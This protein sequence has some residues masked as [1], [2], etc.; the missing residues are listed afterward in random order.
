MTNKVIPSRVRPTS[1]AD[2][3]QIAALLAEAGLH[4]NMRPEELHWKYWQPRSDWP[5]PR[6]F[7]MARNGE[8]LAHAGIV[9]GGCL[10]GM[11]RL[12][13]IH[14]VDWAA[15][16]SATGAGVAL[17]KHIGRLADALLSIGGS[18]HTRQIVP[19]LGFQPIGE[20]TAYVRTLNPLHILRSRDGPF[21]KR[22]PRVAR[23]MW[24]TA[25][26]PSDDLDDCQARRIEPNGIGALTPEFP[27]S[28][29]D[30]ATFERSD[31]LFRYILTCP[32]TPIELYAWQRNGEKRGY[33]LLAFA[34]GQV[35]LADCWVRSDDPDDWR[36]LVQCA[37]RWARRT[38]GAAELVAWASDAVLSHA[39]REC[40]FHARGVQP[41]QLL[42]RT[43]SDIVR[44]H[45]R[46]QML[47]SDAAYS[48]HG[49]PELWA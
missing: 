11:G 13:T 36:A 16:P 21:W 44:A 25:T 33:F 4:P 48:H 15:H 17:M 10:W 2:G 8:I 1:P 42:T 45:L 3:P 20:A 43:G 49:R 26:A 9:Y 40:G 30:T 5:G 47:D 32:T 31:P 19:H 23:S 29:H 27:V 39:L 24:W 34:P 35:R 28:V 41:I 6:S 18:K 37:V 7:V 22:L 14:L 38:S 12:N 46:V